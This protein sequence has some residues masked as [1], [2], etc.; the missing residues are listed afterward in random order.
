MDNNFVTNVNSINLK[1]HL[2]ILNGNLTPGA[3]KEQEMQQITSPT[4]WAK[5]WAEERSFF[6]QINEFNNKRI[7]QRK[8]PTIKSTL[9]FTGQCIIMRDLHIV[10]N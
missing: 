1:F 3:F 5:A 9:Y 4:H 10:V 6:F 7:L 2:Y 8:L